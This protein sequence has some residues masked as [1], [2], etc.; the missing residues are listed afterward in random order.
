MRT[1]SNLARRVIRFFLVTTWALLLPTQ[2]MAAE[3][4]EVGTRK[5]LFLDD[6]IIESLTPGIFA[7]LNRPLKYSGNP[8]IRMDRCWEADMSFTEHSNVLYDREEGLFK[9]WNTVVNYDWSRRLLAYYTSRDGLRWDKPPVG[10]LDFHSDTC[11]GKATRDHNF[12]SEGG[13]GV[14]KDL[15]EPDAAKR[16]KRLYNRREPSHR[17]WAAYSGDGLRWTDY[18][19]PQVNPVYLANDTHQVVFWDEVRRHYVAHIRLWPPLFR[20][21]PRYRAGRPIFGHKNEGFVRVPGLATSE[22]FL[23]WDAPES[24]FASAEVNGPYLLVAPDE[25]DGPSVCGFNTFQVLSYE[26]TYVGFL[27][28]YHN[29]PGMEKRRPPVRGTARSAWM[30]TI[31][32]QLAFSRDGSSWQRLGERRTF[33]PNGPEGSYDAAMASVAQHPIV[34][35]DLGEIWIYYVGLEKGNWSAV[36][37]EN[38]E[39]TINLAMLR[40]DGFISLTG[41]KGQVTTRSLVFQGDKLRINAATAGDAGEVRV[42]ILQSETDEPLQGYGREDS[43]PFQGDAI[44]HTVSWRGITNVRGLQGRPVKL[45][46]HLE[47]AKLFSFQFVSD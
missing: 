43:D 40:L 22:N 30:D 1:T 36:R 44:R 34:R 6:H 15:H 28:V 14:F 12:V 31:D 38:E 29:Y 35:Q 23:Q 46:F 47:Q 33:L 19:F 45:R 42:E 21:D 41:G 7:V 39:G 5:Q 37:G 26:R 32:V 17:V 13:G 16:Y 18:P 9:M 20:H 4:L 10:Q 2:L 24:M 27:T 8:L 11:R 25:R 3:A